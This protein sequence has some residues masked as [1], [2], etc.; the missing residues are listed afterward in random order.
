[1]CLSCVCVW[2]EKAR[3]RGGPLAIQSI[4]S[5]GGGVPAVA[6]R[7]S[8]GRAK[9]K[10]ALRAVVSDASSSVL[11]APPGDDDTSEGQ[12]GQ[13][14]KGVS[15]SARHMTTRG[16]GRR[17]LWI[18]Q[19]LFIGRR[20]AWSLV[21]LPCCLQVWYIIFME[22]YIIYIYV[23]ICTV[24]WEDD[25]DVVGHDGVKGAVPRRQ[26]GGLRGHTRARH[27]GGQGAALHLVAWAQ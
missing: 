20:W 22:I 24:L 7:H 16:E 10:V 21:N 5:T 6:G 8:S 17:R 9:R 15:Y 26:R 2:S 13:R 19:G 25:A 14:G 12:R 23:Y 11:C 3:T 4:A 18:W 27:G 1:M